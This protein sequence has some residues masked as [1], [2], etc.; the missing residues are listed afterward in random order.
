M[1][2]AIAKVEDAIE[3]EE[4][5]NDERVDFVKAPSDEWVEIYILADNESD[6]A[7]IFSQLNVDAKSVEFHAA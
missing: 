1:Y 7:N 6:A 3:I 5:L 4:T 2:V